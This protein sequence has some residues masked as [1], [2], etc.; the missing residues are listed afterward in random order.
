MLPWLV[1]Q[2]QTVGGISAVGRWKMLDNLRRSLLAPLA[3]VTLIVG[4]TGPHAAVWTAAVVVM[5]ALPYLISLPF[6]VLPGR[7]GITSRSHLE[8]LFVM[9]RLTVLFR[10]VCRTSRSSI[11]RA[12]AFSELISQCMNKDN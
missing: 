11:C 1:G 5:L 3:M 2:R 6:A 8:A 12:L 7:A 9:L 10:L 4:W